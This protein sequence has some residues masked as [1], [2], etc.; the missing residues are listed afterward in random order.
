M[1]PRDRS[2]ER[3][4]V[5]GKRKEEGGKGGEESKNKKELLVWI[6]SVISNVVY[7]GLSRVH[8]G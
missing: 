5:R 3:D 2:V 1:I 7:D 4:K 8:V 6:G